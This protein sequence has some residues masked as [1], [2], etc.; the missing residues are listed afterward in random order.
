MKRESHRALVR[1]CVAAVTSVMLA[2]APVATA[3]TS[4]AAEDDG[5][6]A[7]S[8][9]ASGI[10]MSTDYPGISVQAGDSISFSLDFTNSGVGEEVAL[11][12]SGLPDGFEG[13][14]Q[15]NSHEVSSVYVKNGESD[16]L[17]TYTVTVPETAQDGDYKIVLTAKGTSHSD[18]LTLDL[19]VSELDLGASTLTVDNNDQSASG[20]S[21]VTFNATLNNN[22]IKDQTFALSADAPEGW[23]V[24]YQGSDSSSSNITSLAVDGASSGTFTITVQAPSDADATDFTI[25]VHAKDEDGDDIELDLKV[26][27]TGSYDLDF[28]TQNQTLSFNAKANTRNSVVMEVT[29][30]GNAPLTN[31]NLTADAPTDWTVE[32]SESTIDS[33]DAGSSKEVTA[34][35]TPAES[36][37]SG[38]YSLTMTA[39][40]EETTASNAF[41]VTVQ[42]QTVWGIVGV[43]IIVAILGCLA[44]VFRKFGRH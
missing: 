26:T 3:F 29:N 2:A 42:T 14:F 18:S 30:N 37:I 11:S 23:T 12:A 43:V 40:A 41:R 31:I 34:Y 38:D 10:T 16:S 17:V 35:V 20:G 21:S 1:T 9:V 32:F 7:Q 5:A 33:L 28:T 8:V 36:A 25:P 27:V 6:A 19:T 13:Y 24:T 22:S 44:A 15:G 4:M 39:A